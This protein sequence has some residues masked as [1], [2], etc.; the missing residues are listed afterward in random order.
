M[1]L[2]IMGYLLIKAANT[3]RIPKISAKDEIDPEKALAYSPV[4]ASLVGEIC[5]NKQ[6]ASIAND[7]AGFDTTRTQIIRKLEETC[8]SIGVRGNIFYP[9]ELYTGQYVNMAP[10]ILFEI[11]SHECEMTFPPKTEPLGMRGL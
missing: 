9:H 1:Y 8:H 4:N 5:I 6:A 3:G 2:I 7:P 11:E 10:D